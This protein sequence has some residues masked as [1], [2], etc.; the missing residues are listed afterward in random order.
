MVQSQNATKSRPAR[1]GNGYPPPKSGGITPATDQP[2]SK[3]GVLESLITALNRATPLAVSA[4]T[5][6]DFLRKFIAILTCRLGLEW[7]RAGVFILEGPRP[8]DAVCVMAIG[9]DESDHFQQ[10][11][12]AVS[13]EIPSLESYLKFAEI[14]NVDDSLYV[15]SQSNDTPRIVW[16]NLLRHDLLASLFTAETV[17]ALAFPGEYG[18]VRLSADDPWLDCCPGL[19]KAFSAGSARLCEHFLFPL[20]DIRDSTCQA[21]GFVILDS[22]YN[23][24]IRKSYTLCLTRN[25]C[26]LFSPHMVARGMGTAEWFARQAADREAILAMQAVEC[27]E[28]HSE[29]QAQARNYVHGPTGA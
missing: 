8:A 3:E 10:V 5:D 28:T 9:G 7:H 16:A 15:L 29:I 18:S 14:Q 26:D 13:A 25:V 12:T 1:N 21:F 17:R 23:D 4:V 20:L 19:R 22:P 11:R 2:P 27:G 24:D 6:R